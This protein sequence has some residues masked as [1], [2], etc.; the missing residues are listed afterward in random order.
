MTRR[1]YSVK[2][3]ELSVAQLS[4][5]NDYC[6]GAVMNI[7]EAAGGKQHPWRGHR[8]PPVAAAADVHAVTF[9]SG[10]ASCGHKKVIES[11]QLSQL[12]LVR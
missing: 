5:R 8:Y 2:Y 3:S 7:R 6:K 10:Y 4:L 11:S 12:L 1:Q 9:R